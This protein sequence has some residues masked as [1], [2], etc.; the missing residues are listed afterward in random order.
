MEMPK[1]E[2]NENGTFL[3]FNNEYDAEEFLQATQIKYE[4][5]ASFGNFLNALKLPTQTKET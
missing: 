2:H 5:F 3:V 1:V 4:C